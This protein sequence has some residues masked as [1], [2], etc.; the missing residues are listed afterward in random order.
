[1]KLTLLLPGTVALML[2][3]APVLPVLTEPAAAA[4]MRV[5]GRGGAMEKLNL[6][7]A[8]KTQMQQIR[9]EQRTK[10]DAILTDA[11]KAEWQQAKQE[12]RRPNLN[13]TEAQKTQ[14]KAIRQET[15]AR[16]DALLTAEQKQQLQQMRQERMQ[17]RG[18][19]R[20][21]PNAQ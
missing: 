13:L 6:T 2:A 16:M 1:M 21:T 17:N 3:A 12:R 14:M 10:M 5:A 20:Q 4:P 18:Q 9:A 11:Q 7:E 19:R 8:Q 15:K